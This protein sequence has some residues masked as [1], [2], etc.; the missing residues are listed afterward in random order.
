MFCVPKKHTQKQNK[1]KDFNDILM[2]AFFCLFPQKYF[3]CFTAFM[4]FFENS[5]ITL[6]SICC[7]WTDGVT[8]TY[9]RD[10][11]LHQILL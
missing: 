5:I 4:V 1:V 11:T 8:V 9:F 10:A 6:S 3:E 7:S 2:I